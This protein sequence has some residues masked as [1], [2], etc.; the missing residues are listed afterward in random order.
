MA[1]PIGI[2]TVIR[3]A[4]V[5]LPEGLQRVDIGMQSGKIDRIGEAL[6][7]Y[8]TQID[9]SGYTLIPGMID[10][11]THGAVN[12]DAGSASVEDF[13]TLSAY[14]ASEGVTG[15]VPTVVSDAE[16]RMLEAL[17]RISEARAIVRSAKIL[18]CTLEGP[19]L[20][21]DFRGAIPCKYLQAGDA[22]LISRFLNAA[23]SCKLCMTVSPE[24][25]DVEALMH[26]IVSQGIRVELG[27][28]GATYEQTMNCLRA[29]A[30]GF[31]H[32]MNAM[33]PLDRQ[34]PG[35]LGA[36]LESDAYCEFIC[37]GLHLHPANVR[38]LLKTKGVD[39][40]VAI[41]DSIMAA[42]LGDGIYSL[43]T[44]KIIVKDDNAMLRDGRTRAGS[45]L[46][47]RKALINFLHFTSL[48]LHKAILPMTANPA[49]LLGIDKQKGQIA[50]GMDADLVVLDARMNVQYTFVEQELVYQRP[51]GT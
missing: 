31:V 8:P 23:K 28:S 16:T 49:N 17:R 37:D 27:H 25:K 3:N 42:G 46:S 32:V 45:T 36:A 40:L 51:S 15:F 21:P 20:S 26:Y 34:E 11:H 12:V 1:D 47:M 6:D 24:A 50:V 38:L 10:V 18:G 48:P 9:A 7:G 44:Q 4:A 35:I 43:G 29:G 5:V 30:T 14:Y 39:R 33:R 41:S 2:P 22:S 19:F 13:N